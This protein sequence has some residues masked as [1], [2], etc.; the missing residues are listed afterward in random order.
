M[1]GVE[2]NIQNK[3]DF[4]M[5]LD[6]FNVLNDEELTEKERIICSL[7][8]FY[9]DLNDIEDLAIFPD[10]EEA[11]KKMFEFFSAG[12]PEGNKNSPKLIDWE[13]D[14]GLIIPAINNVAKQ[15]V[16]AL[17]YLHWWTF[18]GYYISVGE[19]T[20]S[21]VVSIRDKIVKGKK[22]EKWEREYKR[23]NPQYF[24]WNRKTAEDYD[25]EQWLNSV[26]NKE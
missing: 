18:I 16:R 5:V 9:E 21:T 23:D 25:N 24:V 4:R 14:E 19:S 12:V 1:E 2:Y 11:I 22:L 13:G 15:E 8:I 10:V 6:A 26:W 20:L 7:I 17:D 3:G